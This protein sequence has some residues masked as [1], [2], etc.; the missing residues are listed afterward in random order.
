MDKAVRYD[1]DGPNSKGS[2][3][4]TTTLRQ[5][6]NQFP[7]L[8][9]GE[10]IAFASLAPTSGIA[11]FPVS[12]AVIQTDKIDITDH[13][14]Q[15]CLYPFYVV[16]RVNGLNQNRKATVKEWL[17]TL[18]KWLERQPVTI[19][20]IQHRLPRYP[21]LI[22]N[23]KFTRIF[24]QTPS[25]LDNTNEDKTEDWAIYISAQYQNEFDR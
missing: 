7:G 15:I 8:L 13:V 25:Y 24:R 3:N 17:D 2:D 18:G 23:R 9:P 5:L 20:G 22:G 4:I 14:T 21:A 12:G 10:S 6:L 19:D 1:A 11:I 16:Y